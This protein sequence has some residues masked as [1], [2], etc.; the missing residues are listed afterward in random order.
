MKESYRGS[1]T[2][3]E[4]NWYRVRIYRKPETKLLWIRRWLKRKSERLKRR[5]ASSKT[6]GKER[7]QIS[8]P[9]WLD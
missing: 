8:R 5:T 9:E 7:G 1:K 4:I 3:T 6:V 2:N